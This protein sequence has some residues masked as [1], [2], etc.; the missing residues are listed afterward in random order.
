M[1]VSGAKLVRYRLGLY[2]IRDVQVEEQEARY[3]RAV[4]D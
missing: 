2:P 3:D 4:L 1:V